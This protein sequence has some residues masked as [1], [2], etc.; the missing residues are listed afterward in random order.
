M[1]PASMSPTSSEVR[2]PWSSVSPRQR[3]KLERPDPQEHKPAGDDEAPIGPDRASSM[4]NPEQLRQLSRTM[5]GG[6]AAIPRAGGAAE[7]PRSAVA[8]NATPRDISIEQVKNQID[9]IGLVSNESGEPQDNAI[10]GACDSVLGV[11]G[12]RPAE[13]RLEL[14]MHMLNQLKLWATIADEANRP[15]SQLHRDTHR[16]RQ[17]AQARTHLLGQLRQSD[18]QQIVF[19]AL[20]Q[21][22]AD[23][24]EYVRVARI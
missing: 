24:C 23:L 9:A 14:V 8:P 6:Y 21:G 13:Q 19:F 2:G 3:A 17:F 5:G 12:R 15:R 10:L 4:L 18:D 20:T 11:I 7:A 16:A 22:A 1:I